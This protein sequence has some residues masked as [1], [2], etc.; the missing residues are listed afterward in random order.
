[1]GIK[2]SILTL[3]LGAFLIFSNSANASKLPNDVW[4]YVKRALGTQAGETI[5]PVQSF[6]D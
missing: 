3:L 6:Y 5:D 2:K 1:M 4:K